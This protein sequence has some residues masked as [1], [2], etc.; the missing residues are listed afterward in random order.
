MVRQGLPGICLSG[1]ELHMCI[2]G[3]L[4]RRL[5]LP[6][7]WVATSHQYYIDAAVQLAEDHE[8]REQWQQ[9][10]LDGKCESVLFDGHP[11]WLEEAVSQLYHISG[12]EAGK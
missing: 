6:G 8:M 1:P 2:D 12:Q 9:Y 7:E 4:F 11:E 3:G 10:L 5:G